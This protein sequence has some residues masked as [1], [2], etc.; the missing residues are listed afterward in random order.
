MKLLKDIVELILLLLGTI[1]ALVIKWGIPVLIVV[2]IL[3]LLGV[4]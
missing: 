3:K 1:V 2:G 4:I